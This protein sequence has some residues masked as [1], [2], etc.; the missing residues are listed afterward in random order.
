MK[1]QFKFPKKFRIV[2][3]DA[4]PLPEDIWIPDDGVKITLNLS[5][6]SVDFFKRAARR[7]KIKYQRAI[8]DVLDRYAD[9]NKK[10]A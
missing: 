5:R 9:L 10:I 7:H 4:F 3:R 8:R 6:Y 2:P 1:R